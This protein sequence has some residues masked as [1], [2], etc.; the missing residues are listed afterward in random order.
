LLL[1][2]FSQVLGKIG[3]AYKEYTEPRHIDDI[4]FRKEKPGENN[5]KCNAKNR[6]DYKNMESVHRNRPPVEI[7]AEVSHPKFRPNSIK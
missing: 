3:S 4:C 5:G 1:P 6:S 7:I 2:S